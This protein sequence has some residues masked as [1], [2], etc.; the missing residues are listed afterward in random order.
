[1]N[2]IRAAVCAAVLGVA[3]SIAGAAELSAKTT[4]KVVTSDVKVQMI[5]ATLAEDCGGTGAP[6]GTPIPEA[7]P[8]KK[9]GW[10]GARADGKPP[11][12]NAGAASISEMGERACEQTSM[13]LSVVAGTLEKPATIRVKKVE[14]FDKKGKSVGVLT[15][16]SPL[17]WNA[18]KGEYEAWDESVGANANLSVSYALSAPNWG[19]QADRWGATYVMK[20]TITVGGKDETLS[21]EVQTEA[22]TR[23]P[24]GAVT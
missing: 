5:S 9:R 2:A 10:K 15:P 16:R 21:R 12:S 4:A 20:A 3:G 14:I 17:A 1:M 19:P 23:L 13:Q 8:V 24:P 22:E 7:T 18:T 11:A 6:Y